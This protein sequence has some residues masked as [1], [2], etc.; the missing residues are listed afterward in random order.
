V[1]RRRLRWVF[2]PLLL[3]LGTLTKLL[4]ALLLPV[5]FWLWS[6]RQRVLFGLL[7]ILLLLPFGWQSGWGLSGE[8]DGRGV[9]GAI[10]IYAS[11]WYFNSGPI[12][13]L[14][15]W[16]EKQGATEPVWLVKNAA[17]ALLFL[18]SAAVWL[19]ARTRS[20]PRPALRLMSLPLIGYVLL[21]PTLHPWYLLMLLAFL[22]FLTPAKNESP[23]L[24][25]LPMPWI[26]LSGA[27][28]FS[29]LTYRDPLNFGELEW[30]RQLEWL[31][32]LT[33]LIL[34]AAALKIIGRKRPPRKDDSSSI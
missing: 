1:T 9:F 12:Y 2:S 31:P 25:L 17:A 19:L 4:P 26:Y 21:T 3:A 24:W 20:Q 33:L 30:V 34:A 6:W 10:R 28:I 15:T 14:A 5:L 13:W 8:L 18:L 16:L 27:L 32:T 7:V 22:P 11:H 29:Y 23:W